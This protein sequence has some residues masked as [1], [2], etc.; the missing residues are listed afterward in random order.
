MVFEIVHERHGRIEVT[1]HVYN[2]INKDKLEWVPQRTEPWF[3]KRRKHITASIVASICG[4]NPYESRISALKK[5]VGHEK[6]FQGSAAT[7]HG[8]KYEDVAIQKY[9]DLT[10]EKVIEFGLLESLN[11]GEEYLAGSPDGITASGRLIEVKCPFRRKP[12][13][14]KI[15]GHYVHQVQLLMHILDIG[16]CDF[17]EFV[18]GSTWKQEVLQVTQ[19]KRSAAFWTRVQPILRRFWD[20]VEAYWKTGILPREITEAEEKK[21]ER[22]RKPG[23]ITIKT[24]PE[25]K[26][27]LI[28]LQTSIEIEY[29]WKPPQAFIDSVERRYTELMVEDDESVLDGT[30]E[31]LIPLENGLLK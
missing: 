24:Q 23:V 3:A 28:P 8:N 4:D 7:E 19:E 22:K 6:P 11:E 16:D 12:I 27:C 20:D 10:G 31:C 18:P 17:I 26:Q 5:K 25:K 21:I 2:L 15:P 9:E 13:P 29:S 1:E 14:G 30:T